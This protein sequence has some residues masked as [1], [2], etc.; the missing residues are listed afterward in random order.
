MSY[1]K[2]APFYDLL[3]RIAFGGDFLQSKKQFLDKV[4][5]GDSV[6]IIGGGTGEILPHISKGTKI[7]YV[8]SSKEM[9]EKAKERNHHGVQFD[10][11]KWDEFNAEGKYDCILA[12]Y[13]LDLFSDRILENTL[14]KV[15]FY[16]KPGGILLITDFVNN[17]RWHAAFLG[18][19]YFF[20]RVTTG[21]K[22]KKLPSWEQATDDK[23]KL[24]DATYHCQR[25]IKACLYKST[26]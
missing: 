9:I 22:T 7:T 17:R 19:L 12:F 10:H 8:D 16:L 5:N 1:R 25:F 3:T 15:D 4:E 6:L 18:I 14:K 20:F 2:I 13:F 21:L 26:L 23:F 11:C 24:I